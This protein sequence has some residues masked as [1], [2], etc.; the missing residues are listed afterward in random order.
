MLAY[1]VIVLNNAEKKLYFPTS[2]QGKEDLNVI[3]PLYDYLKQGQK[4]KF[5]IKANLEEIIIIDNEWH[6]LKKNEEGYFEFEKYIES[7]KGN[8]VSICKKNDSGSYNTV[9][10]Y[11]V[12]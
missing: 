4:V 8:D 11:K 5:K 12:I 2:Y 7:Q 1:A 3:E 9:L 10:S 6:H